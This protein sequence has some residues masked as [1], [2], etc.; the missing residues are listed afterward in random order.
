MIRSTVQRP[1]RGPGAE[2]QPHLR[3]PERGDQ[4]PPGPLRGDQ[5]GHL[6]VAH[7]PPRRL[8]GQPLLVG[9]RTDPHPAVGQ[10]PVQGLDTPAQPAGR[11][12]LVLGD[13]VDHHPLAGRRSRPQ[14]AAPTSAVSPPTRSQ[15][16]GDRA[17][18]LE[19]RRMVLPLLQHQPDRPLPKLRRIPPRWTSYNLHPSQQIRPGLPGRLQV[20]GRQHDVGLRLHSGHIIPT[21]SH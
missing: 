17:D 12:I 11:L 7:L 6:D 10:H 9:R 2:P 19:L 18:R 14:P 20:H 1:R 4:T 3:R 13:E 21:R 16:A 5:L 8:P 15:L